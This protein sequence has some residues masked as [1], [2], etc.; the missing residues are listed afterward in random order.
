MIGYCPQTGGLSDF[1]TG[2]QYLQLH[3]ALRGVPYRYINNE[4]DKW[5][6]VLGDKK[7][8]WIKIVLNFLFIFET[9]RHVSLLRS[10][11]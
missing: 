8:K 4:V 3:A 7:R 9:I 10:F 5:L 6:D 11:D 2:R 1:M